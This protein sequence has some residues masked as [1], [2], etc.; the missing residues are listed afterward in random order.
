[1][2]GKEG[3][4]EECSLFGSVLNRYFFF[5]LLETGVGSSSFTQLHRRVS[6]DATVREGERV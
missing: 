5:L 2:G 1:M 3:D 6:V 4:G